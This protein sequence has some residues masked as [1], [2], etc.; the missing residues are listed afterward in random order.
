MN[1]EATQAVLDTAA[2]FEAG[3]AHE[4]GEIAARIGTGYRCRRSRGLTP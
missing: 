4:R 1:Q 2:A 3:R